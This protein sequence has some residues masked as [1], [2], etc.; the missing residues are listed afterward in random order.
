MRIVSRGHA[1]AAWLRMRCMDPG[2]RLCTPRRAALRT[3]V[4]LAH[5]AVAIAEDRV[6]DRRRLEPKA[7]Q[8]PVRPSRDDVATGFVGRLPVAALD[9]GASTG[10][11]G[12]AASNASATHDTRRDRRRRR[13]ALAARQVP[14]TYAAGK[15]VSGCTCIGAAPGRHD[16]GVPARGGGHGARSRRDRI[17]RSVRR[18]RRESERL[19][20]EVCPR[21]ACR[22][23]PW[24]LAV[25]RL[26]HRETARAVFVDR[27]RDARPM[28]AR[29]AIALARV[30]NE[31]AL[32]DDRP[33]SSSDDV[34]R[35][36][37][38]CA[39]RMASRST[40]LVVLR[41]PTWRTISRAERAFALRRS[42]ELASMPTDAEPW[43][44]RSAAGVV[45]RI[46]AALPSP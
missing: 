30:G 4:R 23:P 46:G 44:T 34:R 33:M 19:A 24:V 16:V 37:M 29:G 32:D 36:S 42:S 2:R 14:R 22:L 9:R 11:V 43:P 21:R 3:C 39:D 8:T 7:P 26:P 13:G 28:P 17:G 38:S 5:R 18:H 10:D 45:D 15:P 1:R 40:S 25:R 20:C 12:A 6:A 35:A 41:R 31:A 27:G